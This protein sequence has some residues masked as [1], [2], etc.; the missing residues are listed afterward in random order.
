MRTH[1]ECGG[2][3][4]D[5]MHP[6]KGEFHLLRRGSGRTVFIHFFAA[7]LRLV[8]VRTLNGFLLGRQD[9]LIAENVTQLAFWW[10]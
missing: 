8:R 6:T 4:R 7:S 1:E 5:G 3:S 9:R 2:V 10:L